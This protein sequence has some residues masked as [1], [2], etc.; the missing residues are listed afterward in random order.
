MPARLADL[1]VR[2]GCELRGD[3]DALIERVASLQDAG[4]GSISFLANP[5]YRR[6]LPQTRATAVVID[7]ASA[8]VCPG[9]VLVAKNPYA[10]YA[11]IA[12]VLYPGQSVAAGR[13]PSAIVEPGADVD[14]TAW[15]GAGAFVA[16]GAR[17]G[18]RV[19]IGPGSVVLEDV[20]I[21]ADTQLVARV[22]LCRGVR[23]GERCILQPGCVIGA[24][25]FGHAPDAG[26]YVK[27]PQ[28][29]NVEVGND[30]E[31]GSNS[32]I[33]R[34]AIGSTVIEDGVK[35][36]N[37][38]Q[39][40]HNVRIGAHTV[41]AACVGIS[42]STTIGKRCMLGGMVGIAGHLEICDDVALTGRTTVFKSIDKPGVYS[43]SL[44]ADEA[45]HFH[46]NAARFH[47]LEE[48]ARR[49]RRLEG[50]DGAGRGSDD[51]E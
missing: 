30:V 3:P 42:G 2:F 26:G 47:K 40:A 51:N 10:T 19:S 27:I 32:T 11:R 43:S 15:I 41:I 44:W 31:V 33:D 6:Y 5:R 24:D 14:P 21:G 48:L 28:V 23:I 50:G 8:A 45:R 34:A 37:L 49:V 1:A 17:V 20:E 46:R 13:H 25:G 7:A 38:V 16:R 22:T 12:Q 29:G 9:N 35:I 36:D 18:R 39:V 4:P